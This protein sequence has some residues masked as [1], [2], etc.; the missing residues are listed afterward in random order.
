M[1]MSNKWRTE[2]VGYG[3][4]HDIWVVDVGCFK[5]IVSPVPRVGSTL[6]YDS[7]ISAYGKTIWYSEKHYEDVS[8]A[9]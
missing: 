7:D 2:H 9:Q 4:G 8:M 3:E 1:M 5:M 6:G